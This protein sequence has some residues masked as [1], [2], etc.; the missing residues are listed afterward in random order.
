AQELAGVALGPDGEPLA[1]VPVVLHRVG[2]GSGAFVATDTTTE[3]GGF[4][5]ALAADSAVY[6][7]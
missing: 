4:Q 1:G 7:A 3:E 2:G 5:F 6:F